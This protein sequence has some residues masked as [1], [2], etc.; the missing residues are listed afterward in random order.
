M[1]QRDLIAVLA[2]P[3]LSDVDS[4]KFLYCI[5]L[6]SDLLIEKKDQGN[7]AAMPGQNLDAS[8]I[9]YQA[10]DVGLV[11]GPAE[12]NAAFTLRL[13]EAASTWRLAGSRRAV[14]SQV[15]AYL[16]GLQPGVGATLPELAV[17]SGN[18]TTTSWDV[19]TFDTVQGAVPAHR[20][21]TP[22]N[23]N[24]DGKF[25]P[26]RSWLIIYIH[27]PSTLFV[28]APV[29]GSSAW[30]AF[31]WGVTCSV[32]IITSIRQLVRRWKSAGTYYENII[33]SFGGADGTAGSEFSPL[34]AV[35]SGNP[36]GDF[37]PCGHNVNGVWVPRQSTDA[38]TSFLD[39]TGQYVEC[40]EQNVG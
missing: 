15:Q 1:S 19:V 17:V 36:N 22:E 12:S 6:A 30:G 37:A 2:P 8:A 3:W 7:R 38:R 4:E 31:Q 11:Q 20:N 5:G 39:G 26:W 9:P 16:T 23:W 21:V 28:P 10:E 13:E 34:S 14:L 35:G 18:A 29:W 33:V 40:T 27:S 25:K 24:W 32:D